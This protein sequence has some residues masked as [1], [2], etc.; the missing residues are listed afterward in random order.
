MWAWDRAMS[1]PSG[2]LAPGSKEDDMTTEPH[3][4]PVRNFP[5]RIDIEAVFKDVPQIEAISDLAIPGFFESDEEL[6]EFLT[7]HRAERDAQ[8]A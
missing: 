7:W 1:V 3:E 5:G 4:V 8:L 6:D 2:T